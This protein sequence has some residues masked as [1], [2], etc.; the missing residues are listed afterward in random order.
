MV[1]WQQ[2]LF[3]QGQ[4]VTLGSLPP[5]HGRTA[6][7]G[8][9]WVEYRPG[10][11]GRQDLLFEHLV[12][13]VPWRIEERPMYDRSVVVPRM[14]SFYPEGEELPHPALT[15]ARELLNQRY[16]NGAAGVLRTAGLCL[17]RDG[18]DSVA[19]HSDRIGR[20]SRTDTVVAIV[21]LGERR[22]F[23]IRPVTGGPAVRHRLGGGDLLVMGGRFQQTW[24]HAV[25]KT[26]RPVGP[27]I[28]VQF[29][30]RGAG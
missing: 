13:A 23:L 12:D 25:P 30:T 29:R 3:D 2:S 6:L 16:G 17:Y 27:R 18:R 11:V 7:G 19:W 1:L 28:S 24:E 8:G 15:E 4:S 9:A 14:V 5:R 26:T 20:H 10:W 21:S 22:T